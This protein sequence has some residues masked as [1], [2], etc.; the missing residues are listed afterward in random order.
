L[1]KESSRYLNDNGSSS[2]NYDVSSINIDSDA[3]ES[4]MNTDVELEKT[5]IIGESETDIMKD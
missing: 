2:S 4:N 5:N 1:I 3:L